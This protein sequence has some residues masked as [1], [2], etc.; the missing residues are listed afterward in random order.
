MWSVCTA[1]CGFSQRAVLWECFSSFSWWM[2]RTEAVW[3]RRLSKRNQ[4]KVIHRQDDISH[5]VNDLGGET[6]D[7]Y[8][9]C[10][11]KAPLSDKIRLQNI[12]LTTATRTVG[13]LVHICVCQD[14]DIW[15]LSWLETN[16]LTICWSNN[17]MLTQSS[18]AARWQ[19]ERTC[20]TRQGGNHIHAL[21][22][23][24]RST[25]VLWNKMTSCLDP[26][27][28]CESINAD[29]CVE[30]QFK[31]QI[32]DVTGNCVATKMTMQRFG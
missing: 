20:P 12:S 31:P 28:W 8:F 3:M 6:K 11:N 22:S 23:N 15:L 5:L 19:L 18:T 14:N 16:E 21:C 7:L 26:V 4:H 17:G 10:L 27:V 1:A 25:Y 24:D 13:Y 2:R 29:E 30:L 9:I 32:H